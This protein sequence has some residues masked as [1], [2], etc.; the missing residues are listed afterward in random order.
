[1]E[2][3]VDLLTINDSYN[4]FQL[5]FAFFIFWLISTIFIFKQNLKSR[6]KNNSKNN[7]NRNSKQSFL[8]IFLKIIFIV[9]ILVFF[10]NYYI[11]TNVNSQKTFLSLNEDIFIN[12]TFTQQ[13]YAIVTFISSKSWQGTLALVQSLLYVNTTVD[14]VVLHYNTV[15]EGQNYLFDKNIKVLKVNK[16][17]SIKRQSSH[18][19]WDD[20]TFSMIYTF[21][22]DQYEKVLFINWDRIVLKNI[23]HLFLNTKIE[24]SNNI[25]E[26]IT[27]SGNCQPCEKRVNISSGLFMTKPN[28]QFYK[29]LYQFA[30]SNLIK[31]EKELSWE[32]A[33]DIL[34]QKMVRIEQI[35][36]NIF[37]ETLDYTAHNCICKE[38]ND[39]INFNDISI[40]NIGPCGPLP[41]KINLN[42]AKIEN[43]FRHFIKFWWF[44]YSAATSSKQ[45]LL[46][47]KFR[48]PQ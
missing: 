35:K 9:F 32:K 46:E 33:E 1:M 38:R 31:A 48:K 27:S 44:H 7:N 37:N 29:Q 19:A 30:A 16:W 28:F 2:F 6:S 39:T 13:K 36:P 21:A 20:D 14:I 5:W 8:Y 47:T 24:D 41:W 10:C 11:K 17:F 34:L 45:K 42:N 15:P 18:L 25:Y 12:S 3:I 22:L 4:L 43:C 26:L 40:F 23:D